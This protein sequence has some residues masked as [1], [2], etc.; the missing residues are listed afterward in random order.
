MTVPAP[1]PSRAAKAGLLALGLAALFL[2]FRLLPVATWIEALEVEVR[3]RGAPGVAIFGLVYVAVSLIPGGPAALLTLAAGAVYGLAGGTLLVSAAST[4]AATLAFLL[5]RGALAGRVR[6]MAEGN[7]AYE[8]LARALG[9]DGVRI[10][11]LVRLSPAFPFTV[12]NYLFGLTP[13]RLAPYVLASW[14][15]MLPGTLAYV[16][17]G[18]A[19]GGVTGA[20]APRA[21]LIRIALGVA[22]VVAT[23]LVARFAA[24]AVRRAGIEPPGGP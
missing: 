2:L 6:R 7:A 5:A 1:G 4:T 3:G 18:T 12:V 10:V 11:A 20:G 15:A 13:V 8:S 22:A 16:Y 23:V 24:R 21:K 19:L 9:K 17:L 14:A